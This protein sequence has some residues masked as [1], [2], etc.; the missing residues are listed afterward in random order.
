MK[1][2]VDD[3]RNAPDES[4]TVARTVISAIRCI[5]FFGN[6][7]TEISLDHDISHQVSIG[8]KLERPFPCEE[9]F[10]SVAYFIAAYYKDYD[11]P[12]PSIT[13]H[14]SNPLGIEAMET[15]LWKLGFAGEVKIKMMGAANRLEMEV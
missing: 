12:Y 15:A 9:T 4:W 10:Q 13:L 2:Y 5:A 14:S 6:D 7:I 3:I 1:L 8:S 11:L